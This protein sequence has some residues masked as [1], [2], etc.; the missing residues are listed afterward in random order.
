MNSL[1]AGNL[2]FCKK[3]N[4]N[5]SINS[6]GFDKSDMQKLKDAGLA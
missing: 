5:P 2:E 1:T 3:W 4:V 6:G